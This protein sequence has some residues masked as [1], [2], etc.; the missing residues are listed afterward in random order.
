[1]ACQATAPSGDAKL[2]PFDRELKSFQYD[3]T[4][5]DWSAVKGFLSKLTKDE[6][7]A[8]Y[9][10]LIQSLSNPMG[11]QGNQQMQMQMQQCKCRCR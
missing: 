7:K 9:D 2:D 10:Q 6:G 5:G 4:L 11:M 8:A 3:V 1:M